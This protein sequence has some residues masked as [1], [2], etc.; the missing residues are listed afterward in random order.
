MIETPRWVTFC[1]RLAAT[2][3]L[4]LAALCAN[5]FAEESPSGAWILQGES[6]FGYSEVSDADSGDFDTSN[7]WLISRSQKLS[8]LDRLILAYN[9]DFS[10]SQVFVTQ[11]EGSRESDQILSHHWNAA[12]RHSLA[13][14]LALRPS[15]FYDVVA[16]KETSDETLGDGLYDYEDIGGGFDFSDPGSEEDSSGRTWRSGFDFFFRSYPRYSSLVSQFDPNSSLEKNEKDFTGYRIHGRFGQK[17]AET[18]LG[19]IKLSGLLKDFRDKR[20]INANGIRLEDNR[21][22]FF[23]E[24]EASLRWSLSPGWVLSLA[25]ALRQ[26]VSNLDYY[27]TRNTASLGDDRFFE[28]YYDYLQYAFGPELLWRSK[29]SGVRASVGYDFERTFYFGRN[30]QDLAGNLLFEDQV[31]QKHS[32]KARLEWPLTE[33]WRWVS[34]AAFEDHGSNQKNETTYRYNYEVWSATSGLSFDLS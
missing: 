7:R 9:G 23:G 6:L 15:F 32:V 3:F 1:R 19:E 14:R 20:T 29:E 33:H 4:T 10:Q 8:E 11:E 18:L 2:G 27:D 30:A 21:E 16:I 5:A 13:E 22:D 26:N 28:G 17:L 12:V 31:D 34:A 25:S 24:A